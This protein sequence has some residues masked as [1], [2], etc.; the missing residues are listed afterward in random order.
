MIWIESG[1]K[2]A[3]YPADMLPTTAHLR[4]AWVMGID[5]YPMD[6]FAVKTAFLKEAVERRAL[7]FFEHDPATPAGY[8]TEENGKYSIRAAS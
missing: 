7:V 3:A 6:T 2:H 1:G 5:L 4:P 8:V